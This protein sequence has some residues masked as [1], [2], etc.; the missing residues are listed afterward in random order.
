L[1]NATVIPGLVDVHIRGAVGADLSDG[2]Y[3]DLVRMARHLAS[4]GVTSFVPASM[5]LP[6]EVLEKAFAVGRKFADETPAGCARLLGIHMEG[7]Y[8]SEKKKGA[9]NGAYLKKPDF[10]QFQKLFV[11]FPVQCHVQFPVQ[12]LV[13]Y[14]R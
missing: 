11:P 2:N 4:C 10:E 14:H 6:Y 7:P 5:T 3:D 9:Q 8:F 12:Y 13:Q 1:E